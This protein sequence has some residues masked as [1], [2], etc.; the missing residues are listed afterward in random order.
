MIYLSRFCYN[1]VGSYKHPLRDDVH[2]ILTAIIVYVLCDSIFIDMTEQ[3]TTPFVIQPPFD[4]ESVGDCIIRTPDGTEFKVF[5]AILAMA[6]PI[7]RDMFDMPAVASKEAENGHSENE[8]SL[9]VI[10]VQEDVE[11]LQALLQILYPITPPLI[12]SMMLARNLVTACDKYF[13]DFAKVKLYVRGIL[14]HEESLTKEP[15]ACYALAWKLGLEQEAIVASRHLHSLDMTDSVAA[16][17]IVSQSGDL[18][19]LLALWDLRI[20][21]DKALDALLALA[22]VNVDMACP[23]HNWA[24]GS[25]EEYSER[26]ERLREVA[27]VSDPSFEDVEQFLGFKAG[28]GPVDCVKKR[29]VEDKG[30]KTG[31]QI[32]PIHTYS[33]SFFTSDWFASMAVS[34]SPTFIVQ[35]PFDSQSGGD[36]IIRSPDGSEFKVVK[37]ILSLGSTIF[38]DMFDM[39][40]AGRRSEDE[41]NIPVIPVEEDPETMQALLRLLYPIEPPPIESFFLARKLVTACDKYF[42]NTAKVQLHLKGILNNRQSMEEHPLECYTLSWELG[43]KEEAIAASRY[44]HSVDLSDNGVAKEIFSQSG[45]LEALTKLW[46]LRFRRE[47]ALDDILA[48]AQDNRNMACHKH[49]RATGSV[50]N[51]SR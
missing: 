14:S 7:F 28:R 31:S 47:K 51:Y 33:E 18:A 50:K 16:K 37:A 2:A 44:T 10:P 29:N 41:A 17:T 25:T 49:P 38:R 22:K 8:T 26:K 40:Q 1:G 48:L 45:N 19:A 39:P 21:T 35:P 3:A 43:M 34:V 11:T 30:L 36:C 32:G 46:D 6:S 5:K 4:A 20:R 13:I 42:V 12:H 9:P 23:N 24:S 27:V 15:V